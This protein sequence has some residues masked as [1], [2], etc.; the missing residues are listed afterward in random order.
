MD[1]TQ[2]IGF[3]AALLITTANIPQAVKIIRTKSTKGISSWTYGILLLGNICWLIYGILREDLP[4]I[5]SNSISAGLCGIIWILRL[6]A[7]HTDNDFEA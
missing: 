2:I 6:T 5:L 3:T 4:I 1:Y 7:K